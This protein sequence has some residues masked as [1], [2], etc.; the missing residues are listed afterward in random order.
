MIVALSFSR[1]DN[2]MTS[3]V[4]DRNALSVF[5]DLRAGRLFSPDEQCQLIHGHESWKISD[6]RTR[7]MENIGFVDTC[8]GKYGIHG[9]ENV[10]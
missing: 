8:L 4:A 2:C 10:P 5:G 7:V 6:S 1:D 3:T 9:H